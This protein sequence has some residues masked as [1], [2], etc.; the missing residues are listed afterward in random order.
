[1]KKNNLNLKSFAILFI[2]ST[3]FSFAQEISITGIVNDETGFPVP[4]VNVIKKGTNTGT[5]TD[6]DG[7]FSI[8]AEVGVTLSFSYI[9]YITQNVVIKDNTALTIS[10]VQ[11]LSE[12]DEV[13]VVGYGTQKKSVVT[14]AISGIKESELEDLPITRVEQTLQG[15]ASG[16]T[17]ASNSGQPGSS[18]TVRVRGITTLGSN[19][20]LWV[21]DGVVVDAGGI[22][23]LNQSDI[24]SIEVLKDAASQAIY[25]ARAATGVILITTKKGKSGKL[26]I[27]YNG[28]TGFSSA[29]RKI[30]LLNA[31]QYATLIN[32]KSVAGGGSILFSDPASLG[33]GTDWQSV[34][35]NDG[36]QKSH[37]RA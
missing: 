31:E 25:G 19:D 1:M 30:D 24:A 16:I 17:I 28:Y 15:R 33:E 32:E 12:L 37:A 22:G 9:G 35:F 5:V 34:I 4:G 7:A 11:D 10:L 26:S 20:P 36:A 18:S 2:L 14:G 23:F 6:F 21:V 29:A 13:V 27:N 8:D 3:W